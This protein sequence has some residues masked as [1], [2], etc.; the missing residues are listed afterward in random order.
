MDFL[1]Q[2]ADGLAQ[3]VLKVVDATGDEDVITRIKKE[4][5]T[6][7]TTLEEAFMTA[8]RVRR[9][10]KRGRALLKEIAKSAATNA[11]IT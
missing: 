4:V 10:E 7:S 6:S 11:P 5:G 2:V 1:E 8:I 3:E 9:A